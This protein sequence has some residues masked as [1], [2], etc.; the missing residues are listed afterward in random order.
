MNIGVCV[1]FWS[2]DF[3]YFLNVDSG[4]ELQDHIVALFLVFWAIFILFSNVTIPTYIPTNTVQG[5]S[6]QY[7]CHTVCRLSDDSSSDRCEI[8]PYL[9]LICIFLIQARLRWYVNHELSDVQ[10]GFRKGRGTRDQIANIRWI[11]KKEREFQKKHLFL[12]YWLCQSLWLCG[13]Q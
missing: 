11:I 7:P 6:L 12:L 3:I 2:C 8:T 10:A 5:F 13:S 4:M 9:V 1:S